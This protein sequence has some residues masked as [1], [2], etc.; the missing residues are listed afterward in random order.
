[1]TRDY[2]D[3][4][5]ITD[6]TSMATRF[7]KMLNNVA[8]MLAKAPIYTTWIRFQI[9]KKQPLTFNTASTNKKQNLIADLE[10]EKQGVGVCNDFTINVYYDPFDYGQNP[11]DQIELLD[12]LIA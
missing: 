1:M 7:D 10:V 6:S 3:I 8:D 11:S 4:K 2:V 5:P 12:D 9:G